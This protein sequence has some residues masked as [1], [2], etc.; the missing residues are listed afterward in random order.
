MKGSWR[1]PGAVD[2]SL[3][4]EGFVADFF[5]KIIHDIITILWKGITLCNSLNVH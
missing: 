1:D 3:K 4:E 5:F 2:L